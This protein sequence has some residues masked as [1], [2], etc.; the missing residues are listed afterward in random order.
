[1][2]DLFTALLVVVSVVAVATVTVTAIVVSVAQARGGITRDQGK[3]DSLW[4]SWAVDTEE[5]ELDDDE[6]EDGRRG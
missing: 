3:P 2:P 5:W 6:E 1:M 4:L